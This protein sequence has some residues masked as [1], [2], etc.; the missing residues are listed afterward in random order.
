MKIVKAVLIGFLA[1]Y[2]LFGIA[3]MCAVWHP[4]GVIEHHGPT[5]DRAIVF[6]AFSTNKFHVFPDLTVGIAGEAFRVGPAMPLPE[7]VKECY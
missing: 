7:C 6:R 1:Y 4:M 2:A 3:M 5:H